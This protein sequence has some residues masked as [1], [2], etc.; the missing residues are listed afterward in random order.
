[1]TD[2]PHESDVTSRDEA[3]A[4]T[5]LALVQDLAL[6]LHPQR[7]SVAFTTLESSLEHELGFD[8]LGRVEL[9]Q[10]LERTFSVH[11]PDDVLATAETPRDLLRAV[12][13]AGR[14]LRDASA[15]PTLTM[16]LVAARGR[17]IARR[18]AGRCADWHTQGACTPPT[19]LFLR[20]G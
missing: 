18:H 9:L 1:M 2:R 15:R 17:P 4:D 6:E 5:L 13:V 16:P 11:L 19:S 14:V 10:R 8:S 12:A 3:A 20:R 7:Q